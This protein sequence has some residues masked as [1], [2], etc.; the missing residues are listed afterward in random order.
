MSEL[1]VGIIGCG[2]AAFN[3]CGALDGLIGVHVVATHDRNEQ[4]AIALAAPRHATVHHSVESL[5]ADARVDIVYVALPHNLL[6]PVAMQALTAGRH[7]LVEKPMALSVEDVRELGDQAR[8]KNLR[9]GVF[10]ELREVAPVRVARQLIADGAIGD[11]RAVRI[12]TIIDKPQSYWA[13]GPSGYTVDHWRASAAQAGGGVVL[14]NSIHQLDLVR[15]ITGLEV[16]RVA[17]VVGTLMAAVEVEDTGSA[18]LTFDNGAIG[19]LAASAHSHGAKSQE[20]IELD[21]RRGRLDLPDPYGAGNVRLFLAEDWNGYPV[22]EWIDVPTPARDSYVAMV[23]GYIDAVTS[24]DDAPAGFE[25]AAAALG[26]VLA[27]YESS[28]TGRAVLL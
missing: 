13:S 17:G 15:Y 24:G 22:G 10:F 28:R 14:M 6:A 2:G 9:L 3:V 12:Q 18:T 19:T 16:K 20:R 11:V 7:V 5:V 4:S 1:G 25:D 8:R 21:G 27:I 23:K 26:T